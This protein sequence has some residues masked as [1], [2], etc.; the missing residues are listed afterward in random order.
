MQQMRELLLESKIYEEIIYNDSR[1]SWTDA[2]SDPM[3]G[4]EWRCPKHPSA[5]VK[6]TY[7]YM[8]Y[9]GCERHTNPDGT[10]LEIPV[11]K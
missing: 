1:P 7:T 6:I 3:S 11:R 2:H 8:D 9:D 10:D 4:I 5:E